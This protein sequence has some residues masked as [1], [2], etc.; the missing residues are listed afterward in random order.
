MAI[1]RRSFL[2]L[3]PTPLGVTKQLILR[4]AL[5]RIALLSLTLAYVCAGAYLLQ[6]IESHFVDNAV[7]DC[8][9]CPKSLQTTHYSRLKTKS[10]CWKT[11]Q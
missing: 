4:L 9:H 6:Q 11:A 7:V 2:E 5:P 1:V 10:Q 8:S 3:T